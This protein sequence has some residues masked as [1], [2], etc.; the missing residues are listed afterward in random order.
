MF[1]A[2]T[3]SRPQDAAAVGARPWPAPLRTDQAAALRLY[4]QAVAAYEQTAAAASSA[5][6]RPEIAPLRRVAQR[7]VDSLCDDPAPLLG[8]CT[9]KGL[10]TT[11]GRI[12]CTHGVNTMILAVALAQAAGLPRLAQV[13]VGLAG[14][15]HDLGRDTGMAA[16]PRGIATVNALLRFRAIEDV[17][18]LA[19]AALCHD[20]TVA[21]AGST[22]DGVAAIVRIA[23]AYDTLTAR[24]GLDG[25]PDLVLAF[26][27]RNRSAGFDAALVRCFARCLGMYPPGTAVQLEDGSVGLVMRAALPAS[28][29]GPLVRVCCKADGTP[30]AEDVWVRPGVRVVT[31]VDAAAFGIDPAPV[32]AP[33]A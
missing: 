2:V 15:L 26:L 23:A 30:V 10:K 14:L 21:P 19:V 31:S 12:V 8:L 9:L 13:Q 11:P 33:R 27:L 20:A 7:V 24:E 28:P 1:D 6:A 3:D 18:V 22:E 25:S 4:L 16:A 17:A 32:F 5:Q 29:A